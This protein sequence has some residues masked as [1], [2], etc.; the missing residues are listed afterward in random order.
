M[1][2]FRKLHGLGNCFIFFDECFQQLEFLK[3]SKSVQLL[4]DPARGL[5]ADGLVFVQNPI[6]LQHHCRMQIFNSDGSEAEMCGNAIRGVAHIFNKLQLGVNPVLIETTK[7]TTEVNFI[8]VRHGESFYR[9]EI[10][11]PDFDLV[12]SG[13]LVKQEYRKELKFK[14]Q[15]F[16]PV[17]VN[18]G[19]PHAVIFCKSPM[20]SD[21]MRK[22]GA[23]L[24]SHPNH[25]RN[26]NVEFVEVISKNE[27]KVNVWERGCGMTQACG[28]G[29]CAVAAA[30]ISHNIFNDSVSINMPGGN[31]KIEQS[32]NGEISMT[33]PVQ[34][35]AIGNIS[36]SFIS[37][38]YQD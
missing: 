20:S 26:I 18:V 28:T 2:G 34:E 7:G 25:P 37:R 5:G 22:A 12:A 38:L 9:A 21:D 11:K 10:G 31:L 29:A 6:N 36:S 4:C 16:T 30:G 8:G 3:E 27:A 17:Y 15:I 23:W 24:E 33:G 35:V 14:D 19:N 32:K 1:I 13:E